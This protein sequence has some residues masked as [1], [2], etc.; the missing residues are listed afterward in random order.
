MRRSESELC[1]VGGADERVKE[2]IF[3]WFGPIERM[4]NDR[5]AKRVYVGKYV[6]S[7]LVGREEG[8]Y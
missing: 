1:G 4:G 3:Q 6:G 5:I 2:I 8:D 7:R